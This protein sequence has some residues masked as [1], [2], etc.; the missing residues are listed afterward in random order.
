[1]ASPDPTTGPSS[2]A[3]GD[4]RSPGA[5]TDRSAR[6]RHDLSPL[7]TGRGSTTIA[8]GVVA[9]IAALAAREVHGIADLSGGL[10]STIGSV[11]GRIG[12]GGGEERS[13]SGVHVE[14]GET[15]AAVDLTV[16]VEYP[17][18]IHQVSDALREHVI[19]RIEGMTGLEVT[20]VNISIVDLVFPEDSADEA[21][22]RPARVG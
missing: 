7:H 20:E 21:E 18:S 12:G 1:M 4:E 6:D 9:R 10:S 8:E 17:S 16:K 19:D 14:V 2:S 3:D 11:M 15:Q 5:S 22:S 13:T